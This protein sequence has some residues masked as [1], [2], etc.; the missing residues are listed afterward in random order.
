MLIQQK[1]IDMLI[2][3]LKIHSLVL[4]LSTCLLTATGVS[5]AAGQG[6]WQYGGDIYLWGAGIESEVGATGQDIDVSFNDILD[7]LD[8]AIMGGLGAKK[9]KLMLYSDFVYMKIEDS[10]KGSY[11]GRDGFV[12][13]N[14]K[15]SVEV[16][17]WVVQPM[18]A[19]E[20]YKS[21]KVSI[22]LA[23]GA[24]Y[25]WVEASSKLEISDP[26]RNLKAKITESDNFLDG[27][28]GVR[29]TFNLSD[30]W[31]AVVYVDGGGGDSDGTWQGIASVNYQ[32]DNVQGLL[33][34]RYLKWKF[35]DKVA[36]DDMEISG[37]YMGIKFA[38]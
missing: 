1:V 18:A 31:D 6:E 16:E 3:K 2:Q 14:G 37:P 19:Y 38:F 11:T 24:R 20:V 21:P 28:V 22:D 17:S 27:V 35:D 15:L 30:K 32:F 12:S 13:V 25:L 26:R 4:L 29:S 7:N 10:E 33:G 9:D 36:L 5:V 34:Y 23:A 8:I